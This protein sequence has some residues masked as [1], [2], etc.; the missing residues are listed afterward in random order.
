MRFDRANPAHEEVLRRVWAAFH[1]GSPMP[2]GR[3]P[4]WKELGFQNE[5]PCTDLR[6]AG[7]LGIRNLAYIAETRREDFRQ[8]CRPTYPFAA[9]ALNITYM[10]LLHLRLGVV[11]A[12]GAL[13]C[14]C[15]GVKVRD[16]FGDGVVLRAFADLLLSAP[17]NALAFHELYAIGVAAMDRHW[18]ALEKRLGATALLEFRQVLVAAQETVERV[19]RRRPLTLMD[20]RRIA[21]EEELADAKAPASSRWSCF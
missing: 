12:G 7:L 14:P 1:E 18:R 16:S 20:L 21:A 6:A 13:L 10:L 9:S 11:P 8:F 4:R 3:D 17:H 2:P 19:L 5:D 15:C